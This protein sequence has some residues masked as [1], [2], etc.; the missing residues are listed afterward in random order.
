MLK[1]A[2]TAGSRLPIRFGM[3]V[4]LSL[5]AAVTAA[6]EPQ[7][8]FEMTVVRDAAHG[9]MITSGEFASAIEKLSSGKY[10]SSEKFYAANN[11][12]VAYTMTADF[13]A[14]ADSCAKAVDMMAE[15]QA[16]DDSGVVARFHAIALTNRGVLNAMSGANELARKDFE[17][18]RQ[19][20]AGVRAPTRNL[21]YLGRR[22]TQARND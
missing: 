12:C 10:R 17:L 19:L 8:K 14:A 9:H 20:R 1:K 5:T 15:K 7:D 21:D 2:N 16:T 13:D 22:D 4:L 11:L 18:A 6:H 3:A